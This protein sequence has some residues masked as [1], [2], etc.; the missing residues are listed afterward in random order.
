MAFTL[1]PTEPDAAAPLRQPEN[2]R[3]AA[4]M[5]LSLSL[6]PFHGRVVAPDQGGVIKTNYLDIRGTTR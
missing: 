5:S 2:L 1:P 6:R 3:R 4:A